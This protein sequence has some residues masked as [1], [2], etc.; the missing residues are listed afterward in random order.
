MVTTSLEY[1]TRGG[2][3]FEEIYR[4]VDEVTS[5][6]EQMKR[7]AIEQEM[8]VHEIEAA[9]VEVDESTRDNLHIRGNSSC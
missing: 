4:A 9:L 3:I 8:A 7:C 2:E 5:M 6:N 1:A